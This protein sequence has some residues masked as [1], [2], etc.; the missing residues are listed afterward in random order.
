M[1]K[2]KRKRK[3]RQASIINASGNEKSNA[4]VSVRMYACIYI[5]TYVL[6]VSFTAPVRCMVSLH[7]SEKEGYKN[8]VKKF[9]DISN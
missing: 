5:G 9:I 3:H 7:S 6:T 2:I 8:S 1:T 4:H